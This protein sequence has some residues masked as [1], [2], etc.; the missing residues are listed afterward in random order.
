MANEFSLAYKSLE[1]MEIVATWRN[2]KIAIKGFRL[3]ILCD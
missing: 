1:E 2:R 3:Q